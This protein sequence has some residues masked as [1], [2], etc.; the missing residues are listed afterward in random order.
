VTFDPKSN[1]YFLVATYDSNFVSIT[2]D[3]TEIRVFIDSS[4]LAGKS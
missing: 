2:L 1:V 4:S 3:L